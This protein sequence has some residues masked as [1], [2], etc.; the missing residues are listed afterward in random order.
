MKCIHTCS[1]N[2]NWCRL[3]SEK[4]GKFDLS[5]VVRRFAVFYDWFFLQLLTGWIP[6]RETA[7]VLICGEFQLESQANNRGSPWIAVL[8]YR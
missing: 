8:L 7:L 3:R 4:G 6:L 1:S 2:G 5:E